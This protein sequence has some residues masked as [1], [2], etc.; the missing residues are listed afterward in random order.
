MFKRRKGELALYRNEFMSIGHYHVHVHMYL[1][2]L[3]GSSEC[4]HHVH[5]LCKYLCVLLPSP[6]RLLGGSGET[7]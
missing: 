7:Q 2:P 5:A 1:L 3:Y 6:Q 4:V